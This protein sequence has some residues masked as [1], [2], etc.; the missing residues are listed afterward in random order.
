MGHLRASWRAAG[1]PQGKSWTALG[2]SC[3]PVHA[4]LGPCMRSLAC[5]GSKLGMHGSK[6]RELSA[7]PIQNTSPRCESK[8]LKPTSGLLKSDFGNTLQG[9][10]TFSYFISAPAWDPRNLILD[11]E[12]DTKLL[13]IVIRLTPP[14]QF[15]HA[16]PQA[17]HARLPKR[18]P[19]HS[20]M[21]PLTIWAT[22]KADAEISLDFLYMLFI[23]FATISDPSWLC[24]GTFLK[25]TSEKNVICDSTTSFI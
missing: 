9:I 1:R 7:L 18:R 22:K 25:R 3:P 6:N 19:R 5:T 15:S 14:A 21:T 24:L 20:Q 2:A 23:D 8:Q 16:R 12:I 17:S 13:R 11:P 4:K 10:C